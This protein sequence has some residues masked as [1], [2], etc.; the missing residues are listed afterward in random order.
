M[1]AAPV[2]TRSEKVDSPS[3]F[4]LVD[5]EVLA[6]WGDVWGSGEPLL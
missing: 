4:V 2:I 5:D 6:L 1:G 3:D